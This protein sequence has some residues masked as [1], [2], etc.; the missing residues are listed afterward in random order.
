MLIGY[1]RVS[2]DDQN[3]DLQRSFAAS[4][5]IYPAVATAP[6]GAA[7][8]LAAGAGR[9]I[10]LSANVLAITLSCSPIETCA[11]DTCNRKG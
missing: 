6:I 7:S 3:P 1:A 10:T 5:S 11:H 8:S 9:L 4:V 2:T